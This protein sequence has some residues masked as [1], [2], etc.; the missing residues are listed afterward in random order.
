MDNSVAQFQL[1]NVA[2]WAPNC[3]KRHDVVIFT[4]QLLQNLEKVFRAQMC[5]A[6]QR[7]RGFGRLGL[8]LSLHRTVWAG[9]DGNVGAWGKGPAAA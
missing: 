2:A 3:K 8:A 7:L 1:Q 5:I 4:T 6:L 9:N